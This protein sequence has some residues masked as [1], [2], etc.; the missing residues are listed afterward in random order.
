[1]I[2][3]ISPAKSMDFSVA[4]NTNTHTTPQFIDEATVVNKKIR[5]LSAKK[6]ADLMD[7]ST[8]LAELNFE[9]NQLWSHDDPGNPL[10]QAV[11]AFSGDVYQGM[12]ADRFSEDQ[13][14]FA[15]EKIRI[16]SGLYGLLRPLDLIQA[17]RLEMGT[18]IAIQRKKNLYD[19][20]SEK[21]TSQLQ[22]DLNQTGN[23]LVNLA[24]NEY[25]KAV[26]AKKLKARIITPEF[27]DLKNGQY[28]MISFFA[29]KARGLMCRFV[30]ENSISN[31][32]EMKAFDLDGYNFNPGLSKDNEWVFTRDH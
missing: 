14:L 2:L 25:F 1:M 28:K 11:L 24:S 12:Q 27:K 16:L 19:F 18:S 13:L 15:Q 20:W 10:K 23:V 8:K 7:I 31:P 29:K 26:N 30:I 17:Y 4:G 9:R 32:E 3:V 22:E 6:L 5:A 21:I